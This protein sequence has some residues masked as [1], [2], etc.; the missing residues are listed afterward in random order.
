MSAKEGL[1]KVVLQ[2]DYVRKNTFD[3][4]RAS[5]GLDVRQQ[6]LWP[7]QPECEQAHPARYSRHA[8]DEE[9]PALHGQGRQIRGGVAEPGGPVEKQSRHKVRHTGRGEKLR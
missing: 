8:G 6:C 5:S 2:S 9:L 4:G 3:P 7:N 1:A